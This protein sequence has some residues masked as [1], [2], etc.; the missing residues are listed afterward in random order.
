MVRMGYL[1]VGFFSL[2]LGA[3]GLFVP[4]LPTVPFIIL[5]AFCFARSSPRLEQWLVNN[6]TFG[7][8]I[9]AWRSRGAI[10]RAGKRAALA[11]F[12]LSAAAGFAMLDAPWSLVPAAAA[13]IGATWVLSRPTE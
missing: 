4:L 12:V 8:H 10:S 7:P 2:L 6:E 11:A 13:L 9:L 3:I 5:A 1:I